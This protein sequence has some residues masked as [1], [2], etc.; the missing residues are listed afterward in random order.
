MAETETT[1]KT[2]TI[3]PFPQFSLEEALI[4]ASA[5]Q[6][7]NAGKP[8]KRLLLADA[9]NRKPTSTDFRD[10]LSSSYKYG[11]TNGTEKAEYISLTELGVKITRPKTPQG[12]VQAK[13]EAV[14][15]SEIFKKILSHFKDGKFPSGQFFEN[16]LEQEFQVP[17][18]Y[19]KEC[20]STLEKNGKFSGIIRQISGSPMVMF[21]NFSV[22]ETSMSDVGNGFS[23]EE[24]ENHLDSN[25]DQIDENPADPIKTSN[26]QQ[27][28]NNRV[29]I[30]HGKNASIV[31]QLKEI[32]KFGKLE[33]VVAEERETTSI[34]VPDKVF[35]EMRSCYA[36]IIHIEGEE[37]LLGADGKEQIALNQNVLIE[38]GAAMALYANNI[39]LLVHK[40]TSLPSNLQGLYRCEYEG[41][42]LD[43]ESTM[44]LLKA[45]N[46][47]K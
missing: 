25:N 29:F 5:I 10:L 19:V 28:T 22:A 9:I 21:E 20:I 15:S 46:E 13:Q 7:K 41:E 42:K 36:G 35:D 16:T 17:R 39:I 43:Y 12:E 44:K 3:R 40:G 11:L 37:K 30:S 23:N 14:L 45:F 27:V 33:P 34:P 26:Q 32:L 4:I 38:I 47:F 1:I 6:E 18:Q 2:R 24:E 31:N 8:M